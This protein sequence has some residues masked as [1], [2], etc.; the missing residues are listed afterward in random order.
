MDALVIEWRCSPHCQN[1]YDESVA[2]ARLVTE[3][4]VMPKQ[5]PGR[6]DPTG[7]LDWIRWESRP[8]AL[9]TGKFVVSRV[10][11]LGQKTIEG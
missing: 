2:S 5:E 4:Q 8:V 11:S 9:A 6:G 10:F 1:G 7:L 3:A